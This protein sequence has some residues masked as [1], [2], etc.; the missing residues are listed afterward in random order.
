MC[1]EECDLL[2]LWI[3]KWQLMIATL[4]SNFIMHI[5]LVPSNLCHLIFIH[6]LAWANKH[7]DI[8]V[9]KVD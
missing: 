2:S 8:L 3:S 6:Q 9:C 7:A 5:S 1:K 4:L